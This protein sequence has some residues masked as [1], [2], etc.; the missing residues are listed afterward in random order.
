MRIS[1]NE[2]TW[3]VNSLKYFR[4]PAKKTKEI[5][6]IIKYCLI[7]E[8]DGYHNATADWPSWLTDDSWQIPNFAPFPDKSQYVT[9]IHPKVKQHWEY[10]LSWMQHWH[11]AF[12]VPRSVYYGGHCQSDSQLVVIIA[13]LI[14]HVLDEKV[15]LERIQDNTGW[16][17]CRPHLNYDDLVVELECE[18]PDAL[19]E[20]MWRINNQHR[21][22]WEAAA[23]F[24]QLKEVVLNAIG[25]F[26]EK[27]ETE[28]IRRKE[29]D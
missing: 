7:L 22:D 12:D 21:A 27:Q 28:K 2:L 9:D 18:R 11:D 13:Y 17:L 10:Y 16:V 20:E 24:T 3:E 14:N 1:L 6:G 5:L 23:T 8:I 4:N 26:K 15:E 25:Q 19:T 29:R